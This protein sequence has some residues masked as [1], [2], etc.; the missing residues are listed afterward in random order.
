M[1][2]SILS[3]RHVPFSRGRQVWLASESYQILSA[4]TPPLK[5]AIRPYSCWNTSRDRVCLQRDG[6]QDAGEWVGGGRVKKTT[7][8]LILLNPIVV[9]L[10]VAT[11][12]GDQVERTMGILVLLNPV[13]SLLIVVVFPV[14]HSLRD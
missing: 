2:H 9:G 7:R 4:V 5:L 1:E 11:V 6:D 3:P 13:V 12:F 8:T 10:L 14:W